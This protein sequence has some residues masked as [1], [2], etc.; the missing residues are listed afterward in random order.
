VSS[1]DGGSWVNAPGDR[2]SRE[3]CERMQR[4]GVPIEGTAGELYLIEQR[5]LQHPFWEEI[6]W[7]PDVRTGEGALVAPLTV[8]GKIVGFQA[9]FI[10]PLGRK[11]TIDPTRQ[12]W[13]LDEKKTPNAVFALPVR[14]DPDEV[15]IADGLED[16]LSIWTYAR[17]RSQVIGLPGVWALRYLRFPAG[18]KVLITPDGDPPGSPGA[19][20]LQQG[21]DHLLLLG[22]EVF[23]APIPPVR[24]PKLDA[25]EILKTAGRDGLRAWLDQA[26]AAELSLDGEIER[27]ARLSDTDYEIEREKVRD[28]LRNRG[29]K[30]R[31]SFLDEQVR[32][33]RAAQ[34]PKEDWTET[35]EVKGWPTPV[36][37]AELLDALARTIGEHVIMTNEQ[38]WCIALWVMTTHAF[39]AAVIAAKLWITS[40]VFRSGKTRV[41]QLLK[42]LVAHPE[43][44]EYITP[45]AIFRLIDRDHPTLLLDE[46]DTFI[47]DNEYLRGLINGGF[48]RDGSIVI[49]VPS[50]DGWEPKRFSIFTPMALSGL[51]KLDPTN[52]DRSF[53]IALERKP[54]G[55]KIK[56]LRRRD[57]G[58][59]VEL[60]MKAE[61]WVADNLEQLED[62]EPQIPAGLNDRAADAWELSLAIAELCGGHWPQRGRQA[63]L[64]ISGDGTAVDE[65]V[66]IQLLSDI[67]DIFN[68][69]ED[70]D[71]A[72]NAKVRAEIIARAKELD[73]ITS[74]ELVRALVN[75]E[76]RPWPDFKRGRELTPTQLARLLRPFHISPSLIRVSGA[77]GPEKEPKSAISLVARGYKR[78]QFRRAFE[79]YLPPLPPEPTQPESDPP[80]HPSSAPTHIS[81]DFA[82]TTLQ[83]EDFCGSQPDFEPLQEDP[84][85]ITKKPEKPS[86]SAVCNGVTAK[87]AEM[88]VGAEEGVPEAPKSNGADPPISIEEDAKRCAAEHPTWSIR[89]IARELMQP[90]GRIAQYLPNHHPPARNGRSR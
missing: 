58:P 76:G 84:C 5:G 10:D 82:V 1:A 8:D 12:T 69:K 19:K 24:V 49:S 65:S 64:A 34:Q 28:A 61:R 40:A 80:D 74:A 22:C 13:K 30:I 18:T 59:L 68:L 32:R 79:R 67:R 46:V 57:T 70:L 23:L 55:T 31:L 16:A 66:G 39:K 83:P 72:P 4:D 11:S 25:N 78:E 52:A 51:G 73:R 17:P 9:T 77:P 27:L 36:E 3:N 85:N 62:A 26:A 75:M 20:W 63:A 33:A 37:G 89:R 86:V 60:V 81:D 41:M 56:R 35:E 88:G 6:L 53:R 90:E 48:E 21:V 71:Q 29:I 87:T 47:A 42:H 43:T 38:A 7:L 15:V 14:G 45:S 44:A 2:K 54:P 50:G